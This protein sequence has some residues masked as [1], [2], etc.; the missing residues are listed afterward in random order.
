M[1][2]AVFLVIYIHRNHF[3]SMKGCDLREDG[4]ANDDAVNIMTTENHGEGIR[5]YGTVFR[6]VAHHATI[7]QRTIG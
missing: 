4:A 2:F 1:V 7:P 6:I 3:A 5:S